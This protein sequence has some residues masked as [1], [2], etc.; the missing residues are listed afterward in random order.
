MRG[1]CGHSRVPEVSWRILGPQ[2]DAGRP[3]QIIVGPPFLRLQLRGQLAHAH[4]VQGFPEVRILPPIR[5]EA[6]GDLAGKGV[7][8]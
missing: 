5:G 7:S 8:A 4:A 6:P 3:L 2:A 1:Q